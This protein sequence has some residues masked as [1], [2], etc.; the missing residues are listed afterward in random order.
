MKVVL[1]SANAIIDTGKGN[2]FGYEGK[3]NLDKNHEPVHWSIG[4]DD[5][6]AAS[7]AP[8]SSVITKCSQ[9]RSQHRRMRTPA[10]RSPTRS[11][12]GRDEG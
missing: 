1:Y 3:C 10:W 4:A 2:D 12:P 8:G 11:Y 6:I 9:S 7:S 5:S